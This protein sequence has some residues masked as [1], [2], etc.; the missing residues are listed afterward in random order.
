M[1]KTFSITGQNIDPTW[2]DD[3][4]LASLEQQNEDN[5]YISHCMTSEEQNFALSDL[6]LKMI[7][8]EELWSHLSSS[9][10]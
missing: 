7:Y 5:C 2:N 8:L 9:L 3:D 1:L 4:G 10:R 6:R